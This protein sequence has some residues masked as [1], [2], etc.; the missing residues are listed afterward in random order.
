MNIDKAFLEMFYTKYTLRHL[1]ID[2]FKKE[3]KVPKSK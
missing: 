3:R 1:F 2:I